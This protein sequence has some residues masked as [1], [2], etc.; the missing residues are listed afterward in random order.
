MLDRD[1]DAIVIVDGRTPYGMLTRRDLGLAQRK[2]S[3][4]TRNTPHHLNNLKP[5]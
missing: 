1:I 3:T 5:E 2:T 4:D